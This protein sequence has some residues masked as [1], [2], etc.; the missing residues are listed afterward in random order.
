MAEEQYGY[1]G[2]GEHDIKFKCA[3]VCGTCGKAVEESDLSEGELIGA[4]ETQEKE[5]G[6]LAQELEKQQA[7]VDEEHTEAMASLME[8]VATM[9]ETNVALTIAGLLHIIVG[10]VVA[11]LVCMVALA[12]WALLLGLIYCLMRH[13]LAIL[14]RILDIHE[15]DDRFG[16]CADRWIHWAKNE[17]NKDDMIKLGAAL[18]TL[19]TIIGTPIAGVN[20]NGVLWF[21]TN[22]GHHGYY[23]SYHH[24]G[25]W[26]VR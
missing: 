12:L 24:Y 6:E 1:S 17:G 26:Y 2:K 20:G 11:V 5:A 14:L 21:N 16:N 13:V 15:F 18:C 22:W 19:T 9:T 25:H 10:M 8:R 7:G 4:E 3:R 23:W